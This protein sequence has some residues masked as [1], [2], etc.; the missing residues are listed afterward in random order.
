MIGTSGKVVEYGNEPA[1]SIKHREILEWLSDWRIL[2]NG[3][4]SWS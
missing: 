2:K 1:G 3:S 4:A